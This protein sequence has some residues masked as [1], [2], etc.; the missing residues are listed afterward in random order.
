MHWGCCLIKGILCEPFCVIDCDKMHDFCNYTCGVLATSNIDDT[1]IFSGNG[2][3]ISLTLPI[4]CGQGLSIESLDVTVSQRG[5]GAVAEGHIQGAVCSGDSD[6][7]VVDAVVRDAERFLPLAHVEAC[8]LL[9][10]GN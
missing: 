8:A 10:L 2:Q 4:T 7:F 6:H 5:T 1:A 9:R 3:K